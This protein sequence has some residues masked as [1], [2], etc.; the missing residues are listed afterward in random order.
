VR[1]QLS[2]LL[3]AFAGSSS[4]STTSSS[5]E[6]GGGRD[7]LEDAPRDLTREMEGVREDLQEMA[8]QELQQWDTSFKLRPAPSGQPKDWSVE[9]LCLVLQEQ[10][11]A[12]SVDR[13][14][15][16]FIGHSVT[17]SLCG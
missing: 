9:D 4:T 16:L 17:R 12:D 11:L 1:Q 3:Q 10:G 2:P 13:L 6:T 15:T 7:A 5:W 8:T 14:V